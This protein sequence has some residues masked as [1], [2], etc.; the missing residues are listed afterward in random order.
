M[1]ARVETRIDSASKDTL[2]RP[3][4]MRSMCSDPTLH[5]RFA[6]AA[7]ALLA[8]LIACGS[9]QADSV[10]NFWLSNSNAGPE[11]PVI[12]AFPGAMG[13]IDVWARP[14]ANHQLLGFS[15]NLEAD[16][17]GALTFDDVEVHNPQLQGI[18]RHQLVFDSE[19]GLVIEPG[20]IP[21]FSGF[22][23]IAGGGL[24]NAVGIGP[25]CDDDDP[26]CSMASGL[27]SW[28]VATVTY[29]AGLE[30]GATNLFLEI[31]QQGLWQTTPAADP[32]HNPLDTSAVFGLPNDLVHE[33]D[34]DPFSPPPDHR[35]MH[36]AGTAPDA[37][38]RIATADFDQDGDVDGADFLA[39]QRGLG[40]GTTLAEG[41]ADG[42][43]AVN[44]IDLAAWRFQFG[45]TPAALPVGAAVPEP[46]GVAIWLAFVVIDRVALRRRN[47]AN[48]R[49]SPS[50]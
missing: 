26:F 49:P 48:R 44:G 17:P 4:R 7:V 21:G 30:F 36:R 12:Y 1:L 14:A 16:S 38:I 9:S 39:W 15:L 45:A 24:P 8:I 46:S 41:D 47:P 5:N 37:V 20:S 32:P 25:D 50:P 13:Q 27:P 33:W 23:F 11:A 10:V 35:D 2:A 40:V 34:N 42:N 31:G 29:H 43:G 3:R 6:A 19:T 18:V 22:S 28:H